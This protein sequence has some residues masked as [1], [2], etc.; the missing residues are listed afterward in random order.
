MGARNNLV[1][2]IVVGLARKLREERQ[3]SNLTDG[4]PGYHREELKMGPL[5]P[6][7]ERLDG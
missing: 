6:A 7:L 5:V 4:K 2:P 1:S 3:P